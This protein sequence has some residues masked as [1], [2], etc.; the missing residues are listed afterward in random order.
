MCCCWLVLC[1]W[2]RWDLAFHSSVRQGNM[3]CED[4]YFTRPSKLSTWWIVV[5]FGKCETYR[6]RAGVGWQLYSHEG[7]YDDNG[8]QMLCVNVREIFGGEWSQSHHEPGFARF[9]GRVVSGRFRVQKKRKG[10]LM[11]WTMRQKGTEFG[12]PSL[13]AKYWNIAKNNSNFKKVI[14]P[15]EKFNLGLI[16]L[17]SFWI[18]SPI[19]S[20]VFD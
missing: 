1:Y 9:V 8:S 2:I 17:G 7:C 20:I 19:S 14:K 11:S 18:N 15:G 13:D 12:V 10:A 5:Q 3:D 16:S 4:S 6:Q